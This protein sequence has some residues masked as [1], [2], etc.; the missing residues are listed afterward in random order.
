VTLV[1]VL[2]LLCAPAAVDPKGT[3]C[4]D[5]VPLDPQ[6]WQVRCKA[7]LEEARAVAAKTDPSLKDIGVQLAFFG[8]ETRLTVAEGKRFGASI[9]ARDS[10][11]GD[12]L[13]TSWKRTQEEDVQ[14]TSRVA[15]GREASLR[16]SGAPPA[17]FAAFS[18]ALRPALDDC[19]AMPEWATKGVEG[20]IGV[21]QYRTKLLNFLLDARYDPDSSD[22]QDGEDIREYITSEIEKVSAE[23]DALAKA[24]KPDASLQTRARAISETLSRLRTEFDAGNELAFQSAADL[25]AAFAKA[26][27]EKSCRDA[28]TVEHALTGYPETQKAEEGRLL[29][30]GQCY[31]AQSRPYRACAVFR[32]LAT[33]HPGGENAA[34]AHL[35]CGSSYELMCDDHSAELEYRETLRIRPAGSVAAEAQQKLKQIEARRGGRP[36]Q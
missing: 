12:S 23:V 20:T 22:P 4:A 16:D 8:N 2:I 15:K 18:A 5:S 30:L 3:A 19:L 1:H 11:S 9:L 28:S 33:R 36:A 13:V 14:T 6:Q 7:R 27:A 10:R 29:G 31:Y 35:F 21:A 26:L 24:Q 34:K 17:Q 25:E 32:R